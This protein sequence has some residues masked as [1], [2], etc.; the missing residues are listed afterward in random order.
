MELVVRRVEWVVL[1]LAVVLFAAVFA[2]RFGP[3]LTG[4]LVVLPNGNLDCS[5]VDGACPGGYTKVLG[6][7]N[8]TNA[9]M[10][11]ANESNYPVSVC[12]GD[13]SGNNTIGTNSTG[14]VFMRLFNTTN[15]HAEVPSLS[16]YNF[17]AYLSASNNSIAC[18][19]N[20]TGEG[21]CLSSETCVYTVANLTNGHISDCVSSG[22]YNI[23][24]CCSVAG[25]STVYVQPNAGQAF[26]LVANGSVNGTL[27]NVTEPS[28]VTQVITYVNSTDNRRH[29]AFVGLFNQETVNASELRVEFNETAVAVNVSGV[30]G[31]QLNHTLFLNRTALAAL[32]VR[33][34][35]NATR[36]E[37]VNGS[38]TNSVNFTGTFPQVIGGITV[39]VDGG[40][41]RID[42]VTGSGAM[43]IPEC[44]A[45]ISEDTILAGNVSCPATALFV[46]SGV[47]LDCAG[48]TV[49]YA[50]QFAGAGVNATQ[51]ANVSV[52]NCVFS[53]VNAS[54]SDSYGVWFA[55]VNHSLVRNVSSFSELGGLRIDGNSLNVSVANVSLTGNASP[56]LQVSGAQNVSVQDA[57]VWSFTDTGLALA[58]AIGS[59]VKDSM[60][61]S[62]G[63]GALLLSDANESVVQNVSAE[64]VSG[65]GVAF[66]SA[67][68][69]VLV[70]NTFISDTAAALELLTLSAGNV[71]YQT[72]LVSNFTYLSSGV[73][74]GVNAVNQ[75]LF[76][77]GNG[78]IQVVPG[79]SVP[80][81]AAVNKS[82]LNVSLNRA[83]LNSSAVSFLND[84]AQVT[85]RGIVFG[86]PRPTVDVDDDGV[87]ANCDVPQCVE[88]SFAG[89]V[90]VFNVSSFTSY[91]SIEQGTNASFAKSDSS[92]PVAAEANLTY[93]LTVNV[94]D[95]TAFN[96]TV[97][98][99]YSESVLFLNASPAPDNG[100][101]NTW[102]LGDINQSQVVVINITVQ[103]AGALNN[104]SVLVN[105]ASLAFQN[106]T[107]SSFVLNVSENTTVTS[108]VFGS[109]LPGS[110]VSGSNISNS[111]KTNSTIISST[112]NGSIN[113][114]CSVMSSVELNASCADSVLS[115]SY[116]ENSSLEGVNA[117]GSSIVN[118]TKVN[119]TIMNSTVT[120]A[121]NTNC[122][123]V[124]G[125]E[126]G[127]SCLNSA[128]DNGS[129]VNVSLSES[130]VTNSSVTNGTVAGSNVTDSSVVN[131]SLSGS[132]VV[133]SSVT[134]SSVGNANVTNS[135]L[136]DSTAAGLVRNSTVVNST[137]DG[138]VI[139]S[140]VTNSSV[141]GTVQ[142]ASVAD[143][144]LSGGTVADSNVTNGSVAGGTVANSSM[145][146]S[147]VGSGSVVNSSVINSSVGGLQVVNATVVNG[148]CSSGVVISG[149]QTIACP[150]V[151]SSIGASPAVSGGGGGGGAGPGRAVI[152]DQVMSSEVLVTSPM[153]N[154]ERVVFDFAGAEHSVTVV[155]VL[156]DRVLVRV[157]SAPKEAMILAREGA[158][159]DLDDDGRDDLAVDVLYVYQRRAVLRV[160]KLHQAG[161]QVPFADKPV[162]ITEQGKAV[163][164][165][166]PSGAELSQE[167]NSEGGIVVLEELPKR[168]FAYGRVGLIMLAAVAALLAV[169]FYPRRSSTERVLSESE[170]VLREFDRRWQSEIGSLE[171]SKRKRKKER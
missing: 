60:V 22:R 157:A 62:S 164:D 159:F 137:V 67:F 110:F 136:E 107:G 171:N 167:E 70:N 89:G 46:S 156:A 7:T 2:F 82:V 91:S 53:Q 68:S 123:V 15:A 28:Y 86:N 140:S 14:T 84:S 69:N 9:H 74:V 114:N 45:V 115:G 154:N 42:N 19:V 39:R 126:L 134:N 1:A 161:V 8:M 73:T 98:E 80:A 118:S 147:S 26:L 23:T 95:G 122:T 56:G 127:G 128:V 71:L 31:A 33:V 146:N 109:S 130:N 125:V 81:G 94:T 6:A 41:F 65:Q 59:F 44:G 92:D 169:S 50:N 11:L 150:V 18:R 152:R 30:L 170:R 52:R 112:V 5:F 113:V 76:W 151:L 75:T 117:S 162:R 102:S 72:V 78:S 124:N 37:E 88:I 133:N 3:S 54:V 145:Q 85:L 55:A 25:L 24:V 163:S 100:T 58:G 121:T 131:G 97:V 32:G 104:G 13:T 142:N 90:F 158:R 165:A 87:F 111:S 29:I 38:C 77:D 101:N 48:F 49:S 155:S 149:S 120:G 21:S 12:C 135:S 138:T 93:A 51:A 153:T 168:V 10:E 34:C 43:L 132:E 66:V 17:S 144:I 129:V 57:V 148:V 105:N 4:A 99:A 139:N 116:V 35:P 64:G 119:S 20:E 103:V 63:G 83:F 27:A 166:V 47:D 106:G 108:A 16:A 141:N 79:V 40:E 61:F 36:L 96:S 143:S 160:V